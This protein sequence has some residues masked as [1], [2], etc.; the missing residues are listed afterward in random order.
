MI[1]GRRGSYPALTTQDHGT[2]RDLGRDRVRDGERVADGL[3]ADRVE[4]V[5]AAGVD[6]ELQR[7]PG[8]DRGAGRDPVPVARRTP[9]PLA[10]G[11]HQG[12]QV[13]APGVTLKD[14]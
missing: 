9:P 4:E 7:L 8:A 13:V 12:V 1:L 3:A 6:G 14:P 2:R 5:Q 10:G 11:G